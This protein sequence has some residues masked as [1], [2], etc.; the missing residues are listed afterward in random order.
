MSEESSEDRKFKEG[1]PRKGKEDK[2]LVTACIHGVNTIHT[3]MS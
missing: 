1:Y 3:Y 2:D